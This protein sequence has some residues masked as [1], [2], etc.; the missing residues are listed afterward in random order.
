MRGRTP[1]F[2]PLIAGLEEEDR[3]GIAEANRAF[4]RAFMRRDTAAMDE[5][6]AAG[7]PVA[8]LHPGQPP[9]F[10]RA[11]ILASWQAIMR[12]PQTPKE[13]RIA[14]DVVVVRGRMGMVICREILPKAHLVA[15]NIFVRE[16]DTWRIA[17][18]QSAI[19]PPPK[20]RPAT[21]AAAK[22]DRRNL[23]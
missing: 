9:L 20:D 22:R 4:Y 11:T 6:W 7:C 14:E 19:A 18:H 1:R 16:G 8:C 17:H 2:M 21:S 23:H 10:D 5:L 13:M 3:E 12:N 15:T